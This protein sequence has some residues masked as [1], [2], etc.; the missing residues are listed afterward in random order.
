MADT[1]VPSDNEALFQFLLRQGDNALVLGHRTSEW[2]GTAPALEEDIALAN[3]APDLIGGIMY[4]DPAALCVA[5]QVVAAD[6]FAVGGRGV[7][8]KRRVIDAMTSYS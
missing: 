8:E 5:V 1:T 3:T 6:R 7:T 4:H 2:C